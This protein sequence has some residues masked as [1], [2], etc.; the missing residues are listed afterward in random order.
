MYFSN[1]KGFF[2]YCSIV[3]KDLLNKVLFASER[4]VPELLSVNLSISTN[5]RVKETGI[6]DMFFWVCV[7]EMLGGTFC[8]VNFKDFLQ[9]SHLKS[10]RN[11]QVFI[12]SSK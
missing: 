1:L 5:L 7:L 2:F 6:A 12:D 4:L 3:R 8:K 9:I 11:F 10:T